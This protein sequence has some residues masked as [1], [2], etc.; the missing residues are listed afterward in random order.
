MRRRLSRDDVIYLT[1]LLE[2][3]DRDNYSFSELS[4]KA[5]EENFTISAK[6]IEFFWRNNLVKKFEKGKITLSEKRMLLQKQEK[7]GKCWKRLESEFPHRKTNWVKNNF[8]SLVKS[9][10]FRAIKLLSQT[11]DTRIHF[12]LSQK[13][14]HEV[15]EIQIQAPCESVL[16][17]E[18][19]C[20][21]DKQT[22]VRNFVSYF[23]FTSWKDL[24][25]PQNADISLVTKALISTLNFCFSDGSIEPPQITSTIHQQEN[26]KENEK[27]PEEF[28]SELQNLIDNESL[29]EISNISKNSLRCLHSEISDLLNRSEI[30]FQPKTLTS[31]TKEYEYSRL[32]GISEIVLQHLQIEK[33]QQDR[34]NLPSILDDSPHNELRIQ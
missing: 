25:L 26:E 33:E 5:K 13:Q 12:K 2:N 1:K 30:H 11:S 32:Y 17:I 16:R 29:V 31:I 6:R 7:F 15:L 23:T 14:V 4:R 22:T 8:L 20:W 28:V 34:T 19:L 24:T 21:K 3:R 27:R 9:A 18:G 10:I